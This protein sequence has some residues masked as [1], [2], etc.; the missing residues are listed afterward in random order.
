ML[1]VVTGLIAEAVTGSGLLQ[2]TIHH[3][4]RILFVG[5]LIGFASYAP[6]LK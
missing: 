6:V 3:P 5:L 1:G 4:W 2:Q